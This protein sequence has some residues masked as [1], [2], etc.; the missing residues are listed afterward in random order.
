[1]RRFLA[2]LLILACVF[3]LLACTKKDIP[4]EEY[5]IVYEAPYNSMKSFPMEFE[6]EWDIKRSDNPEISNMPVYRFDTYEEWLHLKEIIGDADGGLDT[7]EQEPFYYDYDQRVKYREYNEWFFDNYTLLIGCIQV[8]SIHG[9]NC[10]DFYIESWNNG[11][12]KQQY[13]TIK[14]GTLLV[15]INTNP[16]TCGYNHS[17]SSETIEKGWLYIAVSKEDMEKCDSLAFV[18][19]GISNLN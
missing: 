2:I 5:K 17:D 12:Y 13:Y 7:P 15:Y 16:G 18:Y 8:K 6:L 19:D 4:R 3:V 1:M 9:I 14:N 11:S 10:F